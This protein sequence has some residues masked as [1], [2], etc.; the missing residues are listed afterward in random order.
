MTIWSI[1]LLLVGVLMTACATSNYPV[2][3]S[4]K[5]RNTCISILMEGWNSMFAS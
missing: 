1:M 2:A 5:V 4:K 3:V